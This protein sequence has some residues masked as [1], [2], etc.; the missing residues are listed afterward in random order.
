MEPPLAVH[1]GLVANDAVTEVV[2]AS[3]KVTVMPPV[4]YPLAFACSFVAPAY[5]VE[6]APRFDVERNSATFQVSVSQSN[7]E[8]RI[9]DRQVLVGVQAPAAMIVSFLGYLSSLLR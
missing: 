1:T 7:C 4:V 6:A 2:P 3:T 9:F 8:V 5:V